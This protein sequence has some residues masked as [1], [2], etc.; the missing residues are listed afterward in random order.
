MPII[1]P[2]VHVFFFTSRSLMYLVSNE[3]LSQTK[4]YAK[5]HTFYD[6]QIHITHAHCTEMFTHIRCNAS[7]NNACV[8]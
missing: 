3:A 8:R 7:H 4:I 1:V 2:Y 6:R 5:K